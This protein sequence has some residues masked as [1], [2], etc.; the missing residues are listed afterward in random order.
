[1]ERDNSDY[2]IISGVIR[3]WTRMAVE[4][5]QPPDISANPAPRLSEAAN[6]AVGTDA[7][8]TPVSVSP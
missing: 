4:A 8:Q 3:R 2:Q 7:A 1:M 5:N 6:T